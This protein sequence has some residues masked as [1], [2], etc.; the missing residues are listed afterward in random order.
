MRGAHRLMCFAALILAGCAAPGAPV[1]TE[2]KVPVPV[3]CKMP[4][5]ARP[6]FAVEALPIGAGIWEQMQALRADRRQRQ[7]YEI[8]LEAAVDACR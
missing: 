2:V 5:I 6:V 7:G 1:V 8:E 3:P 4:T